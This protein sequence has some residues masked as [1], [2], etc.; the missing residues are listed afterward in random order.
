MQYIIET[1]NYSSLFLIVFFSVFL[2]VTLIENRKKIKGEKALI[3]HN[4]AEAEHTDYPSVTILVPVFNEQNTVD[5]T[6][7]S[8][9]KLNYPEDK[10][11]I[12]IV[13]DG[14][15]DNTWEIVKK[16]TGHKQILLHQKENGGKYTALNYGIE[17]CATE[18]IGCLDADSEV[19]AD[20]L[21]H[22]I[23]YFKVW[24]Y[25]QEKYLDLWMRNMLH[26]AH[27]Q[28]LEKKYLQKLEVIN[29][30]TTQKI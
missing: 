29:T 17:N 9:L 15:N 13:D 20:A 14:S 27:F 23:P 2:M 26:L 16:Y 5:K 24:G 18:M 21:L 25:L 1:F 6:I 28:Y 3:N 19:D 11:K 12:M 7:Q 8:L 10:I 22:I 4:D 30:L